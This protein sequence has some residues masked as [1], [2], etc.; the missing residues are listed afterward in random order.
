MLKPGQTLSLSIEKPAAGGRMIARAGGQVVLVAGAIPGERAQVQIERVTKAVAYGRTL[1]VETSSPDR[2][3]TDVDPRCGGCVYAFIDYARQLALKSEVIVDALLRIG[4]LPWALPVTVRP[5]PEDGYRMRARLH[6]RQ[7]RLGFF[8]EGTHMLCDP[9]STRQLLPATCD[10]LDELAASLRTAGFAGD[11]EVELSENVD[12][13]HRAVHVEA[14]FP[15]RSTAVDRLRMPAA[16]TGLSVDTPDGGATTLV[17][18]VPHVTDSLTIGD[19]A[20]ALQ[21]HV[22]AFF[23]GN[24]FLLYALAEHVSRFV[25]AGTAVVDLYAGVGLFSL[26]AAARGATVVAVEGERVSAADLAHNAEGADVTA[27]HDPVEAFLR[28]LPGRIDTLLVDPPRTGISREA[29][30]GILR[31]GAAQIVYV[32]CD[33]ATF[34]RDTRRLL[35]AGYQLRGLDAFDLFPNTP[36]VETVG[37]FQR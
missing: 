28:H 10:V 8:D 18:G 11:A 5:S 20:V 31:A 4:R 6:W 7:G 17:A 14:A 32:S 3:S 35:D 27:V 25:E 22:T 13:S 12:A 19:R 29:L 33:I 1:T 23:Q 16:L 24:R 21:R 2:R 36:H 30:D 34:A 9:R 15:L 37:L 26:A